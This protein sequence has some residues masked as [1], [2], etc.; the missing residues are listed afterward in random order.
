M[1]RTISVL[2]LFAL[3]VSAVSGVT[4]GSTTSSLSTAVSPAFMPAVAEWQYI[5]DGV[6][7]P[8]AAQCY[9]AG[10]RCFTPQ[11]MANSYRLCILAG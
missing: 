6:T 7:P 10:R 9:S 1:K 11:A 4:V 5:S 8:T 2:V 3:A